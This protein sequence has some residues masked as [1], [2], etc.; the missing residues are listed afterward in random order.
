MLIIEQQMLEAIRLRRNW[1][2]SN[3]QVV[4]ECGGAVAAVYLHGNLIA[5]MHTSVSLIYLSSA[6]WRTRTTKSRLN[7]LL[8]RYNTHIYQR[9]GIWYWSNGHQ[10]TDAPVQSVLNDL[11]GTHRTLTRDKNL[12]VA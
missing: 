9:G 5:V 2:K 7:A 6:G 10:F 12:F 3:T 4:M 11:R 8:E 1:R